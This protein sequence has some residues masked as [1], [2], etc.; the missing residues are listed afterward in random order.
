MKELSKAEITSLSA[1]RQV[2][3]NITV[4]LGTIAI[5][6]KDLK[7]RRLSA[8]K[9]LEENREGQQEYLNSLQQKY[10]S[11]RLDISRGLFIPDN[12]NNTN[13]EKL[14]SVETKTTEDSY[15]KVEPVKIDQVD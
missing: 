13:S 12:A 15:D 5:L 1:Y 2:F 6:E 8:E 3:D 10:G 14:N 4:E 9:A 7:T 11:G